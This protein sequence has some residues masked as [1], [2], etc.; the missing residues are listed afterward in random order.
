MYSHSL[1]FLSHSTYVFKS[2]SSRWCPPC[3]SALILSCSACILFIRHYS[4]DSR[5]CSYF[6]PAQPQR[7]NLLRIDSNCTQVITHTFTFTCILL[8]HRCICRRGWKEEDEI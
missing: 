1:P 8:T 2:I 7:H 5:S 4:G 3:V 6:E